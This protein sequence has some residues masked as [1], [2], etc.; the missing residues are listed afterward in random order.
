MT[1][2]IGLF[3]GPGAGKSTTAAKLFVAMKEQGLK[4]EYVQ[5]YVKN[6]AWE[7]KEITEMDAFYLAAKQM[8]AEGRLYG[9]VD[10]IITD[11]PIGLAAFY[12]RKYNDS[13]ALFPFIAEFL[14]RA[15]FKYNVGRLNVFIDRDKPYH[16]HGR[17]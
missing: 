2:V 13:R 15:K 10:Y 8:R 3:S 1:T 17:Y 9:K 16:Q 12:D 7:G 5:E 11:S 6:W 14:K 4:V